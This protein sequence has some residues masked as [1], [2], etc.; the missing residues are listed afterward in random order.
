VFSAAAVTELARRVGVVMPISAAVD[1]VLNR[2]ADLD[3][4][5]AGLLSR[6]FKAEGPSI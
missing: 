1:A 4:T 3:A 6:P 5:I 2:G